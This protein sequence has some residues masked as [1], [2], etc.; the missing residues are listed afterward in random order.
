M[1]DFPKLSVLKICLI[2]FL[3]YNRFNLE[4]PRSKIAKVTNSGSKLQFSQFLINLK[5]FY[6]QI[7][8]LKVFPDLPEA[9]DKF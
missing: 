3:V 7:F 9:T 8:Y 6:R 1:K 2:F 5:K 4:L